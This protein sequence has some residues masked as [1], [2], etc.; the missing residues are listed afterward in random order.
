MTKEDED[1][2]AITKAIKQIIKNCCI[3]EIDVDG[4]PV[5]DVEMFFIHLRMRSI[6]ESLEL[7]FKCQGPGENDGFCGF[8]NDYTLDLNSIDYQNDENHVAD[9]KL[10]EDIGIKMKYPTLVNSKMLF[11]SSKNALT[12]SMEL[13]S[14]CVEYIYD[15][16]QVYD[17]TQYSKEDLITFLENLSME[18]LS[19]IL[20]FF[21]TSPK[22]VINDSVK[23]AKCA[24]E[25]LIHTEELY[26]FF[27]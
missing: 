8:L 16:D 21:V 13:I 20:N 18:H 3:D 12:T 4:L 1:R 27:L 19:K 24:H 25:N 15:G 23:C 5:F 22:V 14:L 11:D 26:D 9:I 7:N 17:K 2:E 10:S 6:G